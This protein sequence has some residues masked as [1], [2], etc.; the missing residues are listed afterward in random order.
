V[1]VST[2]DWRMVVRLDL[3]RDKKEKEERKMKPGEN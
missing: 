2:V 1:K 3:T